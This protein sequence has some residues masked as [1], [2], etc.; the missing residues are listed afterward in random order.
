MSKAWG[1]IKL[2]LAAAFPRR[3]QVLQEALDKRKKRKEPSGGE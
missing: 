2:A 3:A 1:W